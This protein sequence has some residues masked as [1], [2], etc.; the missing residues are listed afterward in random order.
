VVD[1]LPLMAERGIDG[2]GMTVEDEKFR[3]LRLLGSEEQV[4]RK[5]RAAMTL[6]RGHPFIRPP[7][8]FLHG[9]GEESLFGGILRVIIRIFNLTNEGLIDVV[10]L[11]CVE[12]ENRRI[13]DVRAP[14]ENLFTSLDPVV[15]DAVFA[16]LEIEKAVDGIQDHQVEIQEHRWPGEIRETILG[17]EQLHEHIRPSGLLDAGVG[18]E[19]RRF[20]FRKQAGGVVSDTKEA[21]WPVKVPFDGAIQDVHVG[22]RITGSP[23]H[24]D[25]IDGRRHGRMGLGECATGLRRSGCSEVPDTR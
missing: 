25:D 4:E 2:I 24:A 21:E 22:S 23:F 10:R 11:A 5:H 16:W 8:L 12:A 14:A 20:D 17:D 9:I 19:A 18:R 13:A 6:K 7:A 15:D 1:F 3:V